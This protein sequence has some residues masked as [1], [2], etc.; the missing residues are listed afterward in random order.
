MYM[1]SDLIAIVERV[2][3]AI[4]TQLI[5]VN[6]CV[7]CVCVC[8]RTP[9]FIHLSGISRK[10]QLYKL[11]ILYIN[12]LVTYMCIYFNFLPQMQSDLI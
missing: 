4:K 6:D 7:W 1:Y 9:N 10:L 2:N 11:P 5:S 12:N 8:V 3:M